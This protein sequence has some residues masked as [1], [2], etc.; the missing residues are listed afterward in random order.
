MGGMMRLLFPLIGY[1]CVATCI[2]LVAGYGYL[3]TNG[4]LDDERVF[5]IVSLLHGIDID[6]IAEETKA[7][8]QEIPPEQ[9]SFED[10]KQHTTM[11]ML[12][13]Q[14]KQDD[15]EKNILVFGDERNRLGNMVRH[16]EQFSD[17][18]KTFLEARK[19]EAT[20]TG[21]QAVRE[22][23]KNL[24]AKKQTKKLM[25]G[26]IKEGKIDT[27]IELLNGL[28]PKSRTEILL[29]FE[30]DEELA[31]LEQIQKQMLEG[32]PDAT[33]INQKMQELEQAGN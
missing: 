15:I 16:F 7:E 10:R 24:N 18:V 27:V 17:E 19:K 2:T 11:A 14:A 1:F 8:Q 23:W 29:T 26:M 30:S 21:L 25:V 9:T 32:G 5:R 4:M 22:Q 3:R 6:K 33:F 28:P 20:D 13:L 31:M 12:H